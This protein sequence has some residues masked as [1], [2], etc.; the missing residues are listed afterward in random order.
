MKE[1]FCIKNT[2]GLILRE[3]KRFDD[4][5]I[6]FFSTENDAQQFISIC[7]GCSPYLYVE[8]FKKR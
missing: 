5:K 3:N 8:K 1:L 2:S 6:Q 4:A 7:C